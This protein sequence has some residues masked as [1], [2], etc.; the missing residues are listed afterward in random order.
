MKFLCIIHVM[1]SVH[2]ISIILTLVF[3]V[4]YFRESKV[5][6]LY[7]RDL[8]PPREFRKIQEKCKELEPHMESDE[9]SIV[10]NRKRYE[11]G[12]NNHISKVLSSK[13]VQDKLK[14]L[15]AHP[16]DT[17]VEYRIYEKGGRMGWHCDDQLYMKRQYEIVY[18]TENTS[19]S[20][21]QWIDPDTKEFYSISTEPNSALIVRSQSVFHNVTPVGYGSRKILKFAY[22]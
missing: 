5:E 8:L 9:L 22:V 2:V 14:I 21:T 19:N 15:D 13:Y 4:H 11:I 20:K 12:K 17:P 16:S 3:L 7:I 6:F 10:E 18:T 1:N